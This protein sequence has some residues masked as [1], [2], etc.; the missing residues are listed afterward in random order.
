V[1]NADQRDRDRDRVGDPCDPDRDG[2]GVANG[3]DLCPDRPNTCG[4]L[5]IDGD[6]RVFG[7]ELAAL[8]RASGLCATNLD[9]VWWAPVNYDRRGVGLEECIDGEDLFLLSTGWGCDSGGE[10]ICTADEPAP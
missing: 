1:S 6:G 10:I 3:S 5:D 4:D 9:G 7:A 8:G 2:D